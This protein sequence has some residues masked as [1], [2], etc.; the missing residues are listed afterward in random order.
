MTGAQTLAA[1]AAVAIALVA[2]GRR[3]RLSTPVRI[4]AA[5][6]VALLAVYAVGVF[7]LPSFQTVVKHLANTLGKWTYALVGTMA[8]LE[9]GAFVGFIA[10]G[11]FTVILGGVI[12]GEGTI[13]ILPLIGLVWLCAICGDSLSFLIG[14]RV[15]RQFMLKH[16]RRIRIDEA[17]MNQV[18]DY[19]D[20]HGGKTIV[21]G[22]FIGFVRPL[23]PFIAGT[24][25]MPYA[26]FLPYSVLGTGLWGTT[27]C[28]LGYVFWRSFDQVS[29][30]AGQATLALGTV[31][32]VAVVVVLVKRRLRDPEAR[33]RLERRLEERPL[34]GRAWRGVGR[35]LARFAW[36]RVRFV[37]D[38]LTP[39]NLG[40]EFTTPLAV[41]AGGSYVFI[42]F[43]DFFAGHPRRLA[44]GDQTAFTIVRHIRDAAVIDVAKVVTDLGA[45]P[46]VATLVGIAAV[47]LARRRRPLE[48]A[49]LV[50]GFLLLILAVHFAKAAVDRPRPAGSLVGTVGSSYP[51]GHSAYSTVYVAMAVIASR[52]LDGLVSRAALVLAAVLV[53]AVVGATRIYLRAHYLS[54]VLGGFGLGLAIMALCAAIALVV[55]HIRQNEPARAPPS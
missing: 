2:I 19:F 50:G 12:A 40:I 24:S 26:R 35:P 48:L 32:A 39:G 13:S 41:A 23:A 1:L 52:V 10:P 30:I 28:V 43:A 38:R 4:A 3:D 8:F 18:A 49:A 42:F 16:G 11:E 47:L 20:R 53:A 29:K 31:A 21:I 25:R 22:R 33:A 34:L 51:S 54:D 14:R 46:S 36:P 55:G 44:A 15:G 45:L 9:T 5:V 37:W 17:R 7:H 27:F 6:A